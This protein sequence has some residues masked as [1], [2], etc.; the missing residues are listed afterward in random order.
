[1]YKTIFIDNCHLTIPNYWEYERSE[2]CTS[3]YAPKGYGALQISKY[4]KNVSVTNKD[5]IDFGQTI[6]NLKT[7]LPEISV[8]DFVGISF[9]FN[10]NKTHWIYWLLRKNNI[11]LAITYNCEKGDE[12]KEEKEIKRI[13]DSI[14]I[15]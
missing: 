2:E 5:L 4:E 8:G 11:M 6:L 3:I 15:T 7:S 1:M 12:G 14:E 13:I 9:S 10:K